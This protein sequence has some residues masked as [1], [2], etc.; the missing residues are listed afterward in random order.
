MD[1][2]KLRN[3]TEFYDGFEPETEITLIC[4][5]KPEYNLHIYE[6]YFSDFFGSPSLDDNEW[7]GFTRDYQKMERSFGDCDEYIL[8]DV[9]EY[10]DDLLT[11]QNRDY[12][13]IETRKCYN[14]LCDFLKFAIDNGFH[15]CVKVF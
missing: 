14:I 10:L 5:E 12:K 11:Y 4:V 8:I 2:G 1:T 15:I 9:K 3:N 6:G 7:N 13:Y